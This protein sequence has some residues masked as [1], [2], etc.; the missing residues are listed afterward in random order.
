MTILM[1]NRMME[2]REG[3]MFDSLMVGSLSLRV[4]LLA[5][6]I[7]MLLKDALIVPAPARKDYA[8][9]RK[10]ALARMAAP[11]M[12]KVMNL[13]TTCPGTRLLGFSRWPTWRGC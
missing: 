6:T 12:M 2:A 10:A 5:M 8:P 4:P 1:L 13:E 7:E 11:V 9:E 3:V